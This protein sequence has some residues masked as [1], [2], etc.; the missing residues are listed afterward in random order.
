MRFYRFSLL[1]LKYL[2]ICVEKKVMKY[3]VL[4]SFEIYIENCVESNQY[5]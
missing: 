5:N 4:Y 3:V 1:L 2:K